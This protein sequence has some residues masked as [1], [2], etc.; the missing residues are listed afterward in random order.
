MSDCT[1]WL[2]TSA[3]AAMVC[4][5]PASA[6]SAR[7]HSGIARSASEAPDPLGKTARLS[8]LL[9]VNIDE[10]GGRVLL[11]LSAPAAD[12]V[13][14]RYL[15]T[16]SLRSGLGA[17]PTLLDRGKVGNTQMLAFR[18]VGKKVAI[19]FENPR[20]RLPGSTQGASPDFATS[21]VW[22]GDVVATKPDGA[23]V[24]DI[25][26]FLAADVI[27]IA[28]SLGQEDDSL[29]IG[30]PPQGAGKDFKLEPSLSAAM[31]ASAKLFPDNFE[32]DAVQTYVS[33]KPGEEVGNIA[34]D[35]HRVSFT[36]HHSFVRLPAPGFKPRP[37]D[38][39]IGGFATQSVDYGTPLGSD[40]VR[41]FANRFRLEKTDPQAP[42]SRVKKPILFYVDRAATEPIRSAL[43]EGIGWWKQAFDAAGYIDAFDVKLLPEGADPLD[44]R[45]N[46]V[47]W[48][49]RATRGWSYGQEIV[50]PRTGEII[51][52]MVVLGSERARQDI[53]IFQGLVGTATTGRGGPNDPVQVALARL[54]QLGAHEVGHSLGFAHNFEASTQGRASVMDY[55]APRI[56]LVDGR[57]DLSDAYGIGLGKWDLTT[58]DWLY[59]EPTGAQ[60]DQQFADAKAAAAV[61]AGL[62]YMQ[63]ENARRADTAQPWASLWDDGPDPTAELRRLM[64]VRRVAI[65]R[66]GLANL[67][68]GEPVANLRRRF[69]PIYLLHR[70]QLVSAAKS[71]GGVDFA[72]SVQGD[73]R[74]A[75]TPVPAA[76]QRAAIEAVLG[77]IGPD[78]LRIPAGLLPLLSAARNGSDNRQFD[79]E[80]FQSAGGPV[81]DPLVAADV[82]SELVFNTLLAPTRLARLEVQ[83]AT[84]ASMPGVIELLDRIEARLF[85]TQADALGRRVATRAIITMAQVARR[86]ATPPEIATL[87]GDRVHRIAETLSRRQ[88]DAADRAWSADLSRQLLNQQAL[89]RLVAER[90]RPVDIPP[91]DPIGSGGEADWMGAVDR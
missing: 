22:M 81:F 84:D 9:P 3:L 31:P 75:S 76:T 48:V 77:T 14:G 29:G 68:P 38:P 25:A 8:G 41:D 57:P 61:A 18:R 16:P 19:I 49:D 54:R 56:A 88:G 90:P 71:I 40:V 87:L 83:H 36:V 5:A 86:S 64:T 65:D 27:G 91:G 89:D 85:P 47:N 24:V 30:T 51:K 59:G 11:T 34:P 45:Y 55:P 78:P 2:A 26:P 7:Q 72:Y 62:R 4:A 13:Y 44:V 73:G 79:I 46:M 35:P 23:V 60:S 80:L 43:L 42:R 17:A 20:F 28:R 67:A 10:R 33:D 37:F 58:V 66:F 69:V 52:G 50:D 39:R 6:K 21:L 70:Y 12:G 53:Q 1:R 74:E 82:A 32:V 63:D 15:Y